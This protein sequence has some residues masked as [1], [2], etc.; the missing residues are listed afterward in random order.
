MKTASMLGKEK[1]LWNIFKGRDKCVIVPFDDNLISGINTADISY[2]EKINAVTRSKPDAILAYKG[3]VSLI[4]DDSISRIINISA[5]TV[6]SNHTHKVLVSTVKGALTLGA[7]AVAVHI[8]ISSKFESEMLAQAGAI[9]EICDEYGI[10][11][12]ALAYP[13]KE[14]VDKVGSVTDDNYLLMKEQDPDEYTNLVCKC[15]KIAFELGA[16]IIKTQYTGSESS[17]RKVVEATN[18][19]P[20]VIAGGPRMSVEELFSMVYDATKAGAAGV[21]IGRNVFDRSDSDR[22]V[23]SIKKILFE[24][25]S[26]AETLNYYHGGH[27]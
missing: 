20:V 13:R 4:E 7:D 22:I 23:S 26:I 27:D 17:F 18:G 9:S 16:D 8:N 6:N 12:F 1:R 11:F 10:P 14:N 19:V 2:A 3:T 24:G 25:A 21:S 15:V 5:S